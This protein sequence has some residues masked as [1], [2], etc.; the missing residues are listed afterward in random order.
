MAEQMSWTKP[1]TVSSAEREP[2]PT[3]SAASTSST[4]RPAW[5]R[6][7]AA[8]RPFGP[9]P[10]TTASHLAVG[11][12]I[13]RAPFV[14]PPAGLSATYLLICSRLPAFKRWNRGFLGRVW[15]AKRPHLL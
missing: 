4:E 7:M 1:G 9:A 8:A 12:L 14:P 3:V 11:V 2:P 10:T 6:R 15:R 13:K 5:A